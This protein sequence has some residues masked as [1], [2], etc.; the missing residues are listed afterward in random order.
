MTEVNPEEVDKAWASPSIRTKFEETQQIGDTSIDFS[1][2]NGPKP[3]DIAKEPPAEN[4]ELI[5]YSPPPASSSQYY[6]DEY[7][8]YSYGSSRIE[9]V[10]RIE[11]YLPEPRI[12]ME[13]S[14]DQY[15]ASPVYRVEEPIPVTKRRGSF[16]YTSSEISSYHD[17]F[18]EYPI[19]KRPRTYEIIRPVIPYERQS[20]LLVPEEPIIYLP[21]QERIYVEEPREETVFYVEEP[22]ER[23]YYDENNSESESEDEL[24]NTK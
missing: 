3:E 23:I 1:V 15:V 20:V 13:S 16:V 22:Y 8:E 24:I 10:K 9:N 21:A 19:V 2:F 17:E 11:Q 12:L 6:T 7:D 18:Y 4:D 5:S 14:Y